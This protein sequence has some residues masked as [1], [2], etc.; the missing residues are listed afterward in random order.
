VPDTE[1][2]A[3][4]LEIGRQMVGP[5]LRAPGVFGDE[6]AIGAGASVED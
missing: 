3:G 2:L 6:Q 5:E 1:L 4:A